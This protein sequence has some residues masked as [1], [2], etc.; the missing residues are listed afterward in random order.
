MPARKSTSRN[1][2]L[3]L[4]QARSIWWRSGGQRLLIASTSD[5]VAMLATVNEEWLDLPKTEIAEAVKA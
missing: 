3:G 1:R 4:P 2:C 5:H